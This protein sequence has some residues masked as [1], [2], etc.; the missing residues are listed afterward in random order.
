MGSEIHTGQSGNRIPNGI[1]DAP[2]SY[3][4]R[5]IIP[6]VKANNRDAIIAAYGPISTNLWFH[7]EAGQGKTHIAKCTMERAKAAGKTAV[8][9]TGQVFRE[10]GESFDR[11]EEFARYIY[12]DIAVVDDADKCAWTMKA[13]EA[14]WYFLDCRAKWKKHVIVTANVTPAGMLDI[15]KAATGA[16]PSMAFATLDRLHP[17]RAFHIQAGVS[18]R[19]GQSMP[20]LDFTAPP[21][22]ETISAAEAAEIRAA[23]QSGALHILARGAQNNPN[24]AA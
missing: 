20:L 8:L 15:L 10:I 11:Q 4:F 16:N 22:V 17:C 21:A 24:E 23:I 13:V 19:R 2:T 9:L 12:A 5:D 18:L 7:G 6:Q 1:P 14:L 3:R